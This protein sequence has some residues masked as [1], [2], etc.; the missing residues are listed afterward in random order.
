MKSVALFL[1]A[2]L[3]AS[4]LMANPRHH[5]PGPY[6]PYT[7]P[8]PYYPPPSTYYPPP[9]PVGYCPKGVALYSG[10]DVTIMEIYGNNTA[11]IR[12]SFGGEATVGLSA[13]SC[14]VDYKSG[15]STGDRGLYSGYD[16]T[17][18]AL[19]D[20]AQARIRYSFGGDT[21]VSLAS[22]AR[23]VSNWNGWYVNE[24]AR[25][26]GYDVTIIAVYDNGQVRIRY[27]FGGDSVVPAASLVK[28]VWRR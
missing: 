23:N 5:R 14:S 3:S 17:V 4:V 8:A 16:I 9:A 20:N 13:L 27:S 12:Y 15:W 1:F 26:S 19:Y 21:V 22:M 11:R 24:Q 18:I 6:R 10:Y 7:P 2:M 28:I 25:Y